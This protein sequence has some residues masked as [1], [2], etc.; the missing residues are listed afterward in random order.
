MEEASMPEVAVGLVT[1]GVF[2]QE[3]R[4]RLAMVNPTV[5]QITGERIAGPA[6]GRS[7]TIRPEIRPYVV[8]R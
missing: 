7:A 1:G 5:R 6:N 4:M 3:A 2:A 8:Q